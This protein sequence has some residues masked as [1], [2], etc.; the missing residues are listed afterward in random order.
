MT[1]KAE[2][3]VLRPDGSVVTACSADER[4]DAIWA[5]WVDLYKRDPSAPRTMLAIMATQLPEGYR[6]DEVQR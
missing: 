3:N 6:F 1:T 5:A 4:R 2:L